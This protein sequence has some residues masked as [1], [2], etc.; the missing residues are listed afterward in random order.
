MMAWPQKWRHSTSRDKHNRFLSVVRA[1]TASNKAL[2]V[3]KGLT[4]WPD[5]NDRLGGNIDIWWIVHDG[6]LLILLAYVL[7]QHRT[8]K[9][10][11]LRVF[12]VAQLE[13]NSVQMKKDLE[14]FLYH[15][16][17][18]ASVEVIEMSDSGIH[19]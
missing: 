15:L 9:S 17:I 12:T 5:S 10:C 14:K 7:S 11:K 4:Q 18:E 2:I 3:A 16:R 19:S 13:D 8:W 1:V 6:G